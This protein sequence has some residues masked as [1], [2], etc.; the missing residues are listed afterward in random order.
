MRRLRFETLE[1]RWT[2]TP[3]AACIEPVTYDTDQDGFIGP[4]DVLGIVQHL[5]RDGGYDARYDV[6]CDGTVTPLDVLMTVNHVNRFGA[7]TPAAHPIL[8][9]L[10][11]PTTVQAVDEVW[12]GSVSYQVQGNRTIEASFGVIVKAGDRYDVPVPI[13]IGGMSL[14]RVH[15]SSGVL[16]RSF[17]GRL[18]RWGV[19][20]LSADLSGIASDS[21]TVTIIRTEW[22][23]A[24]RMPIASGLSWTMEILE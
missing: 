1:P 17:S 20:G 4:S 2:P 5:N 18:T 15:E 19:L 11:A 23:V 14:D 10:S 13:E 24:R 3:V 6:N 12:I 8:S 9:V 22:D 16:I 21:L 7:G